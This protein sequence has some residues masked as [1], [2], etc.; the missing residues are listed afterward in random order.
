MSIRKKSV[1]TILTLITEHG[2]WSQSAGKKIRNIS[3]LTKSCQTKSKTVQAK[4]ATVL[5]L[6]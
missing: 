4:D 5:V 1:C 6:L 2:A 3:K